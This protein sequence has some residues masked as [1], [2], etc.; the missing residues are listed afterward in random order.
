MAG[1]AWVRLPLG[2]L[3]LVAAVL[4]VRAV[5]GYLFLWGLVE[6]FAYGYRLPDLVLLAAAAAVVWLC[7]YAAWRATRPGW[8]LALL[9]GPLVLAALVAEALVPVPDDPSSYGFF[10]YE[11]IEGPPYVW[12]DLLLAAGAVA[13]GLGVPTLALLRSRRGTRPPDPAPPP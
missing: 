10:S 9:T 13:V 3:A 7:G 6:G 8:D 5:D 2:A 11:A 12:V 4:V 1:S